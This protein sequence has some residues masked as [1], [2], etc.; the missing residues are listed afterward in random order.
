M[1]LEY[2]KIANH[3]I[4]WLVCVPGIV[5]IFVQTILFV[6][7]AVSTGRE[8]GL[9]NQQ[10]V[11]A[12]RSS[13]IGSIGP[14]LAIVVGMI[15][16]LSSMGGPVA[17]MRLSYI[18]SVTYELTSASNAAAA[19]GSTIG[20]SNMTQQAFACGVWVMVLCSL[21]WMLTSTLFA[22]KMETLKERVAGN[23]QTKLAVIATAGGMGAFGYQS[24]NR[25]IVLTG[26]DKNGVA[27][28]V[29]FLVMLVLALIG[30]KNN[31]KWIKSLGMTIA[32]FA[33]MAAAILL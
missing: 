29:G 28:I 32:M 23:S 22:D 20:T 1:E 31:A 10:F 24:F 5:L 13:A 8:M 21:G 14:S 4:M 19:V 30:Q 9:T 18:G 16:L 2:L 27:V 26:I 3:P 25:S 15:A 7:K 12:A 11:S 17:W 6:K 33:G